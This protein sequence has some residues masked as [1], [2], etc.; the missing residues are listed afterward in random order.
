MNKTSKK[1]WSELLDVVLKIDE[2]DTSIVIFYQ[3]KDWYQ[4]NKKF[5]SP[6]LTEKYQLERLINV[7][8]KNYPLDKSECTPQSIKN[9]RHINP[10]KEDS[11]LSIFR[12]LLW[13]LIVLRTDDECQNCHSLGMSALFDTEAERVVLECSV[14]GWIQTLEGNPH[15]SITPTTWR[16]AQNEDLKIAGLI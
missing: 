1:L 13:E 14:C 2:K 8:V 16:L 9:I 15:E 12:S 7:D 6:N 3:L 11:M 10:S 4:E 5:F